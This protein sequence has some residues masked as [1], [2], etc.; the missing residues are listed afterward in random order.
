MAPLPASS[1]FAK[2]IYTLP[3]VRVFVREVALPKKKNFAEKFLV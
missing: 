3:N 2:K 1:S